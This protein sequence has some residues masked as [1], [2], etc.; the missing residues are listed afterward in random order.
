MDKKNIGAA[1]LFR[2][3]WLILAGLL[4]FLGQWLYRLRT[5]QTPTESVS[6]I[7]QAVSQLFA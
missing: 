6:A 3:A 5:E 7:V 1:I 2:V 4:Y